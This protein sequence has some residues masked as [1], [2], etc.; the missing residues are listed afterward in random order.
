MDPGGDQWKEMVNHF[1]FECQAYDAQ[2][3][4]LA[5]KIGRTNLNLKTSWK[6]WRG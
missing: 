4:Q 6:A 1:L 5:K 2:Q 3:L